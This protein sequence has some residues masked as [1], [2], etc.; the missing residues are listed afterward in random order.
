MTPKQ[1]YDKACKKW[2]DGVA[3]EVAGRCI[4]G[5]W[6]PTSEITDGDQ[7]VLSATTKAVEVL[8]EGKTWEEAF[9]YAIQGP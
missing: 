2:G 4:V 8:G 1:A 7:I 5:R 3:W 9:S 6:I